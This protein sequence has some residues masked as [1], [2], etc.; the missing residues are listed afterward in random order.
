M[1]AIIQ[2]SPDDTNK[3]KM[4]ESL[5]YDEDHFARY[6][7]PGTL[8]QKLG[9]VTEMLRISQKLDYKRGIAEGYNCTGIVYEW[10][11][12]DVKRN[13]S[14]WTT[15]INTALKNYYQAREVFNEIGL[16]YNSGGTAANIGW[17]I[18]A[19]GRKEQGLDTLLVAK[20]ILS[21]FKESVFL[22]GTLDQIAI[23]YHVRKDYSEALDYLLAAKTIYESTGKKR[24]LSLTYL[25]IADN[26]DHLK[27]HDEALS[28][29]DKSMVL[30]S[31]SDFKGINE[32]ANKLL[33]SISKHRHR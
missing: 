12:A 32:E 27:K 28:Y 30:A 20:Q 24:Y 7:S 25:Q 17:L 15:L 18:Y 9:W 5:F 6:D 13:T 11:A 3:V 29:V 1:L 16:L 26:L 4:Y 23:L 14:Q 21:A 8:G 31:E 2:R 19:T 22:A 10:M 33:I